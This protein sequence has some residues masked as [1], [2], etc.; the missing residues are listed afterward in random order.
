MAEREDKI[1][2]FPVDRINYR[3]FGMQ[4]AE[5]IQFPENKFPQIEKYNGEKKYQIEE[6]VKVLQGE[7]ERD[8]V[9]STVEIRLVN[10]SNSIHEEPRVPSLLIYTDM[11]ENQEVVH[12]PQITFQ[13]YR[14]YIHMEHVISIKAGSDY[15]H[16]SGRS[17]DRFRTELRVWFDGEC[18]FYQVPLERNEDENDDYYDMNDT[19]L[20][21]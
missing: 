1:I 19:S 18:E 11:N 9:S 2:P 6:I 3:N 15:A 12:V 8:E 16:I 5:I 13:G 10:A 14:N 4:Q 17:P 20:E 7:L 21:T